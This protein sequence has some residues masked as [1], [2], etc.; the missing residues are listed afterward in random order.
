MKYFIC[1][2]WHI[3]PDIGQVVM[4][5]NSEVTASRALE[6]YKDEAGPG[7]ANLSAV[8][9]FVK[10][11]KVRDGVLVLWGE[12]ITDKECFKRRLAGHLA[13]EILE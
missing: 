12:D 1:R 3:Q 11:R 5:K 4:E 13:Q 6:L 10:G 9:N 7:F 2:P 8:P